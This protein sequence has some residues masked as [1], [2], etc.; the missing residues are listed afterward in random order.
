MSIL[1]VLVPAVVLFFGVAWVAIRREERRRG[2][3]RWGSQTPSPDQRRQERRRRGLGP[4]LAW[5]LR[6]LGSRFTR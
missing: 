3:R 1:M 4:Y 5:V 6:S 2:D